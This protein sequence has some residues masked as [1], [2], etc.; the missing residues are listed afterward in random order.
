VSQTIIPRAL[1]MSVPSRFGRLDRLAR[2]ALGRRLES[3]GRGRLTLEDRETRRAFGRLGELAATIRIEDPRAYRRMVLGGGL[4]AADA[5]IRGW[6]TA[7]DL[8]TLL[9]IFVRNLA[10]T[11]DIESGGAR[12]ARAAERVAHTLRRNTRA[13]SRRNIHAH[14]DLG[15]DLFEL[16]LD[17]TMTYSCGIFEAPDDTMEQASVRKLD[18]VCRKLGLEPGQRVLEIGTGWGSLAMHAARH[19]GCHVTTTTVSREQHDLARERIEAAGLADLIDLRLVDY[20][21]LEGR[22][23]RVMSIEMIEAV[24]HDFLPTYFERCGRLLEPDGLMLLQA[25]T[26]PDHRY[27]RYRRTVDFI[28]RYVFPGS[29]VPSLQAMTTAMAGGSDLRIVHLEDLTPHY[30]TTLRH[31]R[32]TF[33]ER[34]GAVR[35]LG[36]SEE[37]I[38]LWNY[39][40][41]YCE[42]GFAE[43][44][45]GVVQMLLSRPEAR[46]AP[47]R[48]A[49]AEATS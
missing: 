1:P 14:Y 38:R 33:N 29:C 27:E 10:T 48:P 11:D 43:R 30:A 46:P 28:Q 49:Y 47:I 15:N 39:Y 6:W 8:T 25:I 19:Y 9:R 24:G 13:G 7:D 32:Q 31:W 5:W 16:F 41:C 2:A 4:G 35:D 17:P 34:L 45:T 37:F 21:D 26:M 22:Y 44:Y 36:Y 42:A 23:D 40:L 3:I 20:R 12:I 18:R